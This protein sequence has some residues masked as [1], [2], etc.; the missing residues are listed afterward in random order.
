VLGRGRVAAIGTHDK[1]MVTSPVYH[2]IF[3]RGSD[4]ELE[5]QDRTQTELAQQKPNDGHAVNELEANAKAS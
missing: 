1:L 2:A 4:G 3:D 5:T